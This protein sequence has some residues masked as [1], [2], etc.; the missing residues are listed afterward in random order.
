ML[1][2]GRAGEKTGRSLVLG[3]QALEFVSVVAFGLLARFLCGL[4]LFR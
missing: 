4:P 2:D 1:T 3:F